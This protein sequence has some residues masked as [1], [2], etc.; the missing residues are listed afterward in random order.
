MRKQRWDPEADLQYCILLSDTYHILDEQLMGISITG[1][2]QL[3]VG[4]LQETF[5]NQYSS[6]E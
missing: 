6:C 1:V 5:I 3:E 2:L 4:I